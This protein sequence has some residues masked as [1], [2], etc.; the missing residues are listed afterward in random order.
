MY[1]IDFKNPCSVYFI[2]IGGISM[3]GLAEI[4]HNAGFQ[5]SGSDWKAS[6]LLKLWKKKVSLL[7]MVKALTISLLILTV[8]Y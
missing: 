4:L 5:V 1:T 3:S 6:L 2:G 7:N 8:P